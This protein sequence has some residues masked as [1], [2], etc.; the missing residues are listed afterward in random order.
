MKGKALERRDITRLFSTNE[1]R[2]E[3]KRAITRRRR[4]PV[5]QRRLRRLPLSVRRLRVRPPRLLCHCVLEVEAPRDY[6]SFAFL[7][8][9]SAVAFGCAVAFG[10]AVHCVFGSD[11]GTVFVSFA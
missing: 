1:R 5:H 11:S 4:L 6:G 2:V 3:T 8:L 10:F 9:A 7:T